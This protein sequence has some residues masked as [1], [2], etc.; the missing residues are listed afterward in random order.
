MSLSP[1]PVALIS[2]KRVRILICDR[3]RL[4]TH[5]LSEC[6]SHNP[7]Y[8]IMT[9]EG[10][11]VVSS[12]FSER[13]DLA[14]LSA[15]ID[16]A[17]KTGLQIVR[18]L[19]ARQPRVGIVVLIDTETRD[20]VLAA[21]RCG[22]RGVF[23]RTEPASEL[24]ACVERVSRGELWA[25]RSGT[26]YVLAALRNCP[27]W[28]GIDDQKVN[29]LSKRELEVAECAAQ[30][31]SNKQI[32]DQLR[33]SEHTVKNYLF[34]VFDKLSVSNRFELLFLLYNARD[35]FAGKDSVR[36]THPESHLQRCL[37]AAEAGFTDAQ[38]SVGLA[39]LE[40]TELERSPESAYYWLRLAGRSSASLQARCELLAA[41]IRNELPASE[42]AALE[43]NINRTAK[44]RRPLEEEHSMESIQQRLQL[45]S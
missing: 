32:A 34:R 36:I 9:S 41:E 14:V 13:P 39:Y 11:E 12:A 1:P 27:T 24:Q 19:H 17:A 44:N 45:L 8:E 22:A 42:I 35:G 40:G 6:L 5:L 23:C 10:E 43:S 33:L 30:G 38:F 3:S 20:S 16:G 18:A 2:E 28:D 37:R 31:R 25:G 15:D 26:D 4:S 29:V 7:R 21:F